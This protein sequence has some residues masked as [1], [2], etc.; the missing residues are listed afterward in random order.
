MGLERASGHTLGK[1][2]QPVTSP[3]ALTASSEKGG[4]GPGSG[5]LMFLAVTVQDVRPKPLGLITSLRFPQLTLAP[6]RQGT[7]LRSSTWA[8]SW[9]RPRPAWPLRCAPL[10]SCGVQKEG[11]GRP[12]DVTW[13]PAQLP[14]PKEDSP[15]VWSS[16]KQW[17][18]GGRQRQ[19]WAGS[20]RARPRPE[21]GRATGPRWRH[22]AG[23]RLGPG[24]AG[25]GLCCR[26]HPGGAHLRLHQR[27]GH[28]L[29]RHADLGCPHGA[30]NLRATCACL[31]A[32]AWLLNREDL[33]VYA[34]ACVYSP[35][36]RKET[37][38]ESLGLVTVW[39]CGEAETSWSTSGPR[40][41]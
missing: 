26:R 1:S 30:Y 34:H 10:F 37:Q 16:R 2:L 13:A 17:V 31:C 18:Q 5:A 3:G 24:A 12:W 27:Q 38:T 25:V 23:G 28:H 21:W 22:H 6:R 20:G 9:V 32:C 8:A 4:R 36:H 35:V 19:T 11:T 15:R 29:L 40:E 14:G 39:P 41:E 33:H 7:C